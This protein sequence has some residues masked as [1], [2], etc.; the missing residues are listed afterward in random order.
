MILFRIV[1]KVG[2]CRQGVAC[3]QKL[4]YVKILKDGA[5]IATRSLLITPDL[6]CR[7]ENDTLV[8]RALFKSINT[9]DLLQL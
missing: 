5:H 6:A 1:R 3:K 7:F 4:M 9:L 8:M 2:V